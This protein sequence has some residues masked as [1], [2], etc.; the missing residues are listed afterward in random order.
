MVHRSS[1][2]VFSSQNHLL[3]LQ[4]LPEVVVV[5]F[6]VNET[7]AKKCGNFAFV[8]N[9]LFR[10]ISHFFAKMNTAKNAKKCEND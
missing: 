2:L 9:E 7:F 8:L 10:E 6:P 1:K 4:E 3:H 5:R